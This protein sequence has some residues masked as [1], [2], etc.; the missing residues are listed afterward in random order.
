MSYIKKIIK[1][2]KEIIITYL[3]QYIIIFISCIIYK[4]L[5]YNN[6]THFINSYCSIILITFY[7]LT[8]I[9]LYRKNKI[10]QRKLSIKNYY[11]LILLGISISCILNMIIF[12][13]ITPTQT[14]SSINIL[15]LTISSGIVG[16][17]YEEIL[18][19]QINLNRLKKFNTEKKSILI[20][21]LLFALIHIS[22]IKIFY[23]FILG[24]IL[25]IAYTK[26][27][28]L[29]A[30][31][32]IHASANLIALLLNQYNPYILFLSLIGI[33][34]SYDI[35]KIVN[36]TGISTITP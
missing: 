31:I 3:F 24:L 21:S 30:P 28:N 19:R 34:V 5:G 18:F 26:T 22:P 12:L 9:Y 8:S 20:N 35:F 14:T 25:N 2:L 32:I 6:L 36:K 15:I 13:I 16:P 4:L 7:I 11:P 10:P 17:I 33:I 27:N 29:K 23:A 1:S